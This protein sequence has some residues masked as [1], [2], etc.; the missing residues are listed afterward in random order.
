MCHHT[1]LEAQSLVFPYQVGK[2]RVPLT[3]LGGPFPD[4]LHPESPLVCFKSPEK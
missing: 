4:L 3:T 1:E 2:M